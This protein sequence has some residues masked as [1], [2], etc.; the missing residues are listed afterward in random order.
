LNHHDLAAASGIV[1]SVGTFYLIGTAWLAGRRGERTGLVD[2]SALFIG[3]A[4]AISAVALGVYTLYNPGG[5]DKTTAPAAMS[6]F[7]GA[8]LLLTTAGDIR[9]L[10]RGGISGITRHLWR[11]CYRLFIATGSFFLGQQ[12]VFPAFQ[13]GSIFLTLAAHL[14]LPLLIYWFLR[15]RFSKAY[16]NKL[17]LNQVPVTA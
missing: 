3:L 5:V 13:R 14:P 17:S 6:F 1:G 4:G 9:M 16:K 8:I 15:V 2:W 10:A 12:Q 7:F 11:M